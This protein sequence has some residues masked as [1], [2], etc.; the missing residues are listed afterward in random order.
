[1]NRRGAVADL[2]V[3]DLVRGAPDPEVKAAAEILVEHADAPDRV[4]LALRCG[5]DFVLAGV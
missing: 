1:M 2:D 5:R 3:R 4:E